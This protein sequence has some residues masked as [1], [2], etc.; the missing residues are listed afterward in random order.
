MIVPLLGG[1]FGGKCE[2]HFE[3]HVAALARAAG[4][5]VKLVFSRREEFTVPDH[6]RE[7]MAI[8]LETGIRRDGTTGRAAGKAGHRQRGLHGGCRVLP[9]AR[10]D[11][12][13]R[14]RTG[15]RT[16]RS[17][18][19]SRTR[20]TSLRLGAGTDRAPGCWALEQHLDA[21][22]R[23]IGLDPVE[24]R[25]RNIVHEGDEGPTRQVF[26]AIGAAETLEK[27]C[28]LIGY[29]K[30]LPPTRR[31]AWPSAGGRRSPRPPAPS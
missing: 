20:T 27:A 12:R 23:E 26:N 15:S 4:R 30:E 13:G 10:R 8:E 21:V 25:R 1:G 17:R 3:A 5:P 2:P 22:A 9:A 29:G 19:S 24:L 6:R 7:G 31:S 28:E 16:S 14:A 18:P 11:A